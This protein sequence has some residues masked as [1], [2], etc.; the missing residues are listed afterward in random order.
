VQSEPG[1]GTT[2]RVYLPRVERTPESE[3]PGPPRVGAF[4]GVETILL[5]ED[6]EAVR[7]L[8]EE[9]LRRSG[10]TVLTA[11]DAREAMGLGERH[12]GPIHLLI[13]DVSMP[14]TTGPELA[15]EVTGRRPEVKVL[16]VS[17]YTDSATLQHGVLGDAAFLQKPFTTDAFARKVREVLDGRPARPG[18][19]G[20]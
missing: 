8:M 13:T 3:E 12:Q 7:E 20:A 19:S 1:R 14:Q 16:Y 10:Y 15:R 18:A 5:A 4:P 9:I 6:E 2:F 17:G 11:H